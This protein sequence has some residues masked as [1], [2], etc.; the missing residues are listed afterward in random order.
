MS[1]SSASLKAFLLILFGREKEIDERF[2]ELLLYPAPAVEPVPTAV[3]TYTKQNE[4]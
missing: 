1:A 3:P 2:V 4:F